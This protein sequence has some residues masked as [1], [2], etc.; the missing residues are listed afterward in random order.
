MSYI[1]LK[2]ALLSIALVYYQP[3]FAD[4]SSAPRIP[5]VSDIQH[6][7]AELYYRDDF[8][9]DQYKALQSLAK[10]ANY[11]SHDNP[12]NA[13]ALVWDAIVLSTLAEKKGGMG[14]LSLV[15]E[16]KVKLEQAEAIDPTVLAGSVYASLGTLYAKVPGWPISFGSD[17]K[18]RKYFEKALALNPDGLDINYFYADFLAENGEPQKALEHLQK[19]LDAPVLLDRPL[20]DQGRRAQA[21]KLLDLLQD[22]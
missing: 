14:A 8:T 7:W 19:A 11:L 3:G 1:T 12:E 5:E 4:I 18:A 10:R 15:R 16:A 21:R 20:A 2:M 6:E 13:E 22:S 17:S 9:N